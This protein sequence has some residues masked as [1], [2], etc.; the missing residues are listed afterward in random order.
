MN[1]ARRAACAKATGTIS[2]SDEGG[3]LSRAT[4]PRLPQDRAADSHN[5][6]VVADSG[7]VI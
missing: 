2:D 5:H 1:S 6:S 4:E 3:S 7:L